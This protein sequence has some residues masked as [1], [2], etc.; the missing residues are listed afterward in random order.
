MSLR[1]PTLIVGLLAALLHPAGF[2]QPEATRLLVEQGRY[3]QERG[4]SARAAESWQKLLRANA[5]NIDALYGM[6]IAELNGERPERVRQYAARLRA[7][8]AGDKA[9][10]LEQELFL[11]SGAAAQQLAEARQQ[12][13]RGDADDAIASYR[14]ALGQR[15]PSGELALE[16]Y[17]TLAASSQGWREA[18]DGL[19]RLARESPD[20][21]R[22]QL[23]LAQVLT[24]QEATRRDGI[25]RLAA[26]AGN[27]AVGTAATTSWR[28]A[29]L[30]LGDP[31]APADAPLLEAYLKRNTGDAEV[32]RQLD[33]ARQVQ[34]RSRPAP[35][36]PTAQASAAGFQAIDA[37]DLATAEAR[38]TGILD[39]QPNN[40]DA[41]GGLGVIRLR[42][43]NFTE[44]RALLERASAQG[45]AARWR[46]PLNTATYWSL[47]HEAAA[48]RAEGN[49]AGARKLL[50]QAVRINSTEV[51]ARLA[52][53]DL[54]V[55]TGQLDAAEKAYRALLKAQPDNPDVMRGLVG[56]LAQNNKSD[57]ALALIDRLPVAQQNRIGE[58]GR[59]RATRAVGV[60]KAAAQR[61]DVAAA[62]ASL[63]DALVNDPGNAW[64]RLELARVYLDL[65]ATREARNLVDGLLIS[66]P[67]LPDAL[68]ASALLASEVQDWPAAM[69]ALDRI[70]PEART[71]EMAVLH[72]RVWVHLQAQSASALA[73]QGRRQEAL[74]MLAQAEAYAENDAEL[75]GSVAQAYVDTGDAGRSLAMMRTLLARGARPDA[76]LLLQYAAILLKT[77]Q[78]VELAGA[79]RQLHGMTLTPEQQRSFED[80]RYV[81]VVRQADGL[82]QQGNLAA[83][84]DMLA[85]VLAERPNDEL[86]VGAL[87]RMYADAGDAGQALVLYRQLLDQKPH[88]IATLLGAANMAAQAKDLRFAE[89]SIDTAL[90][91]EPQ[92]P[93]V[94]SA[95]A[96]LYRAQG[97]NSKATKYLKMAIDAQGGAAVAAGAPAG[98]MASGNPFAHLGSPGRA[99]TPA[100]AAPAGAAA[101]GNVLGAG[102][103]VPAPAPVAAYGSPAPSSPAVAGTYGTPAMAQGW[104]PSPAAAQPYI[105][106]PASAGGLPAAAGYPGA[107]TPGNWSTASAAQA[108]APYAQPVAPV[109]ARRGAPPRTLQAELQELEQERSPTIT[110]G[111]QFSARD[112]EGGMSQLNT[113]QAPVEG[114]L[115]VGDGKLALRITPVALS[116]DRIGSD[117]N[118]SSRFGGGPA[119][120]LAQADG[121]V[122]APGS[123]D[124]SGVGIALAY[125][126]RNVEADIGSTPIGF[127]K[128]NVVGGVRLK[129]STGEGDQF[130]Y[131]LNL[132]RRAVTDSLLSFAGARDQRIGRTWGAV[133]ASGARL[134]LGYNDRSYGVYGNASWHTLQGHN[135]VSNTR[136]EGGFGVYTK[137]IN[138]HDRELT[139]GL[140]FTGMSYDKNLRYFTYGHGG[141]FSP[142]SFYSVGVPVTWAQ[143]SDR[144]SYQIKGSLG[145]QSFKEDTARYF[146]GDDAMQLQAQLSAADALERELTSNGQAMYPG[147]SKTGLAYN[148]SAAM[149]YQ[150]A[151]QLFMGGNVGIDN[152]RDYRQWAGSVYL[153]YLME[154]STREMPLPVSPFRSSFE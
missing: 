18:R 9:D 130:T 138:E 17:Q 90:A 73:Q 91:L 135:V 152:A 25:R 80:L 137:L 77:H 72:R 119:A 81:Y 26:L 54:Q 47:V 19:E 21:T 121:A 124:Q 133:T 68:F 11:H 140:N 7:L 116:T 43:Q 89:S 107:A 39:R 111:A 98:P 52:L 103:A 74:A 53:A 34:A 115:A 144:L 88:D 36:S 84:Y 104:A 62:R 45:A 56:V 1:Q 139:A 151:P 14:S 136:M 2:A 33:A 13:Q 65:G 48:M 28:T 49:H 8:G 132:S 142:Q 146:P 150:L 31:P 22:V 70:A 122:G 113:V 20:D 75:L 97:K 29:L 4:D 23:A 125:L 100:F 78:D 50:E 154:P 35:P 24:Y 118:T 99:H 38:F 108:P 127:E 102:Y 64:I 66:N 101:A 61:G 153:R 76:G 30:W 46:Q 79:L 109:G 110:A 149:E 145:V 44:A 87:A 5:D 85:P 94:L 96:R 141:Y 86:A 32:R 134:D 69:A 55:E 16:Y 12:A 83:A 112:G 57:E 129:G 10:Q 40:A 93:D 148:L 41:L 27:A 58:V 67:S 147:Q 123:Q 143:R 131:G 3:W 37:G 92:N 63:E 6:G 82:R 106:P 15:A 95:A 117:Y 105:P 51:A 42:Q 126:G 128:T 114:T 59:L 120:S 60:A 71:Q